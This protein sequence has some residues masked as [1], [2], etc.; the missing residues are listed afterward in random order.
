LEAGIECEEIPGIT[1]SVAVPAAAG[2]PVTHRGLSR[3]FTV[4]T[5]TTAQGE[6]QEGLQMDFEAL[7]RIGGTLV[8]LMGMH[9]L[10]EIAAGLIQAG[11]GPPIRPV[12]S[13]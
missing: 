1:S 8:I 5:G 13:S 10:G 2:I 6:G 9:H 7:A 4:I 3:S 11:K 12:R